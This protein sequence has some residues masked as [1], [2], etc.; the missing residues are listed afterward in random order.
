MPETPSMPGIPIPGMVFGN[1]PR[2]SAPPLPPLP[3]RRP[4][5]D[6]AAE[7]PRA[8]PRRV[9]A[10]VA[11]AGVAAALL[12]PGD[13]SGIG[14]ALTGITVLGAVFVGSPERPGRGQLLT[15]AG[16]VALLAVPGWRSAEWLT[17]WYVLLAV[18]ATT[19]LVVGGRTLRDMGFAVVAP[20]MVSLH[21]SVWLTRAAGEA[22]AGSKVQNPRA[23]LG[24]GAVTVALVG[25]FGALF[26]GAD[27]VFAGLLSALTPDVDDPTV[28]ANVA[29]GVVVGLFTALGCYLRYARPRL[30]DRDPDRAPT[31]DTWAWAVPTGTVLVV[32]VAFLG[33][34]AGAMIGGQDYVR[35]TAN[36]TSAEYARSGFWQ[37]FAVTA[38][39]IL[40]VTVAW[41][42]A[43]RTTTRDRMTVRGILGGLCLATLLVVASALH[44]MY[45]YIDAYGA[46][47]LRISVMAVEL[48]LG[49]IVV[50]LMVAGAG[51]GTRHLARAVGALVIGA[52]LAFAVYNPDA[53]IARIN[54]DRYE[55]SVARDEA[56]RIDTSYL[57]GLSP[58]A[59]GQ[60]LRLPTGLRPCV[61]LLIAET[62]RDKRGWT[63]FTVGRAQ[64]KSDL[65]DVELPTAGASGACPQP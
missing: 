30:I 21:T 24:V 48:C 10:A 38:L 7:L 34:Q 64:A 53:Q 14:I 26:A 33:T 32:F 45:L 27:A 35:E 58:D 36:L 56:P 11:V 20:L 8:A 39:T 2:P 61:L 4:R 42:R 51:L 44:R 18:A 41:Q 15:A 59:T 6:V 12:L 28:T 5:Y 13:L 55:A 57:S 63:G 19:V 23:V 65:R 52:A 62:A 46:T 17:V 16:I 37:L 49:A 25:V 1:D 22:Y 50:A 54:V 43:D 47:R 3:P 31:R 60:L 40:V 29:V 9:L